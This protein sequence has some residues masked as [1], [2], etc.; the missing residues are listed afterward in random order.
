MHASHEFLRNLALILGVA[1]LTT[2]V[3]QRLRLPVVFGYLLAGLIVGP[4]VPVPLI[5]DVNMVRE[6]SEL[7]VILIMFSLGLEFSLRRLVQVGPGPAVIAVL[8]TSSMAVLGYMAGRGFGWT[9]LESV[10]AGAMVSISSTTIIVKAFAERRVSGHV[11][12]VVFG[13]RV[14][15][16]IIAIV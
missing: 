3:F 1:A 8:Q 7:G 15:Q 9:V 13:V 5:A 12:D 11:K 10:Y 6:L 14:F 16:D 2:I 4:H